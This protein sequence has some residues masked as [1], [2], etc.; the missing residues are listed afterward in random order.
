MAHES[1]P[2]CRA[3]L[4]TAVYPS[5]YAY[6]ETHIAGKKKTKAHKEKLTPTH[7]TLGA[8]TVTDLLFVLTASSMNSAKITLIT[9]I[10]H[11]CPCFLAKRDTSDVS[12]PATQKGQ[13]ICWKVIQ[14]F[15]GWLL[16]LRDA[17]ISALPTWTVRFDLSG[18]ITPV[19]TV[20]GH[21]LPQ[22]GVR[23][24]DA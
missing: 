17:P 3:T 14:F 6:S 21:T 18:Y 8:L 24:L 11:I 23:R 15:L 7:L 19:N 2:R 20:R 5:T 13:R 22:K 16:I 1:R 12:C 4:N 9:P 10:I